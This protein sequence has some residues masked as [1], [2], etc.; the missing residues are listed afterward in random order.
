MS[1]FTIRYGSPTVDGI[2][3]SLK[4]QKDSGDISKDDLKLLKKIVSCF[5]FLGENPFH[6]GLQSHEIKVLT[7][8]YDVKIFES[9]LENDTPSAGRVFWKYGPQK[10][11]ITIC[12]IEPHPEKQGYNRV[13]LNTD[14]KEDQ[15]GDEKPSNPSNYDLYTSRLYENIS[16]I[17]PELD[18]LSDLKDFV[19]PH[20]MTRNVDALSTTLEE[21][22]RMK[23]IALPEEGIKEKAKRL[24]NVMIY[25]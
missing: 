25:E 4:S 3:T 10:E 13:K 12:A 8:K 20:A 18:D 11:E 7:K 2:I 14:P 9:Y 17:W 5:Y 24:M 6:N 23:K 22:V 21:F 16:E 19:V 1:K 15:E